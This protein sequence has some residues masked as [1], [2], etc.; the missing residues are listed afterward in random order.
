MKIFEN[1]YLK[2]WFEGDILVGVY[3]KDVIIGL[4]AA[5]E[6]QVQE[7][8]QQLSHSQ[9]PALYFKCESCFERS[10]KIHGDRRS[11]RWN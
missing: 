2:G 10:K 7:R 1:Q 6:S 9:K 8:N 5:K 11:H 3:K 4:E